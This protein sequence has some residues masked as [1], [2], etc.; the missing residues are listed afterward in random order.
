[1]WVNDNLESKNKNKTHKISHLHKLLVSAEIALCQW[2]TAFNHVATKK[3]PQKAREEVST[4]SC[5]PCFLTSVSIT[6]EL[7]LWRQT[8][9]MTACSQQLRQLCDQ[10]KTTCRLHLNTLLSRW[11][12]LWNVTRLLVFSDCLLPLPLY[13]GTLLLS[14]LFFWWQEQ[15]A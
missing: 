8:I 7:N 13:P 3:M 6:L 1:M 9:L 11:G 14:S 12:F 10:L 5:C 2:N 4:E 15:L